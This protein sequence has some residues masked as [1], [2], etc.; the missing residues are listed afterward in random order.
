MRINVTNKKIIAR[1]WFYV[2][3]PVKSSINSM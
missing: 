2:Y 1:S 3:F